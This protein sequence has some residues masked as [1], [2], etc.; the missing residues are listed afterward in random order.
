MPSAA[1]TRGIGLD[2][3]VGGFDLDLTDEEA[4]LVVRASA[5]RERRGDEGEGGET[6]ETEFHGKPFLPEKAGRRCS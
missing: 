4:A 3:A 2:G 6:S 1:R 5:E